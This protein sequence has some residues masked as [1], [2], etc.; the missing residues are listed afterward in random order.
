MPTLYLVRGLPG[1]GKSTLAGKLAKMHSIEHVESD[2][3]F[4]DE[5]SGEYKFI[6]SKIGDAHEWCFNVVD[7]EL[8]Q[9]RSVVVSN[10]FTVPWEFA[11][12]L[13][14]AYEIKATIQIIE[15]DGDYGNLHNVP[16]EAL[17]RMKQRWIPNEKLKVGSN[18]IMKN[19]KDV[20]VQS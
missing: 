2:M 3:F 20:F 8:T 19:V 7:N 6:A 17:R 18:V 13:E 16:E 12:Y 11:K 5:E 14:R 1:S 4:I 15:C 9:G 10:T